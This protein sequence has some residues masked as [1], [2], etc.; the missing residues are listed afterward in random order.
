MTHNQNKGRSPDQNEATGTELK[1]A[2]IRYI[3][4][5]HYILYKLLSNIYYDISY[6]P[7]M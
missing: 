7:I 4:M 2:E 1:I 6:I 5:W 3:Y